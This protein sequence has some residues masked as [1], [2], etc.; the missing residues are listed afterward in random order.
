[1]ENFIEIKDVNCDS[2]SFY[3]EKEED[4]ADGNSPIVSPNEV[5]KVLLVC[6]KIWFSFFDFFVKNITCFFEFIFLVLF[7]WKSVFPFL[8]IHLCLRKVSIESWTRV[9]CYFPF[10]LV[11]LIG[12]FRFLMIAGWFFVFQASLTKCKVLDLHW[13]F[14]V[15]KFFTVIVSHINIHIT[16]ITHIP[17]A[18]IS[19]E[20]WVYI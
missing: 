4:N 19:C 9:Y 15:R 12:N 1:M 16:H 2:I 10:K 14:Q 8:K 7:H 6:R 3:R 11:I 20:N 13:F 18:I 5:S 17:L